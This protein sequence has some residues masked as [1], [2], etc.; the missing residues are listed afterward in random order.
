MLSRGPSRYLK[1]VQLCKTFINCV[2]IPVDHSDPPGS[3]AKI[4]P[5]LAIPKFYFV[6][7]K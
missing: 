1:T 3:L 6:G 4:K 7:R 5:Q 2:V